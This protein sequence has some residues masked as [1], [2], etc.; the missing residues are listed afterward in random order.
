MVP[1]PSLRGLWD[2][3]TSRTPQDLTHRMQPR[4][5]SPRNTSTFPALI[6]LTKGFSAHANGT[7]FN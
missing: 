2:R 4:K 7:N 6:L 5:P 1:R 3:G